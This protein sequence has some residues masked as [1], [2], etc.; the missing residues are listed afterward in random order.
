MLPNFSIC[1]TW[2]NIKKTYN[3]NKFKI[4]SRTWND[5]SELPEWSYFLSDIHD[6]F[7]YIL[8]KHG[9][10]INNP[11]IKIH[12]NN[13]ENRV[14]FKIKTEYYVQFFTPKTM[15]LLARTKSF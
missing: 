5:K 14:T 3:K 12:V 9:E 2:K 7:E 1:Y 10:R 15:K 8:E 4:S 6:C 11:S 13:I